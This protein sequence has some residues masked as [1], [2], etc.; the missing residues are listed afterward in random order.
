MSQKGLK[1]KKFGT[2]DAKGNLMLRYKEQDI[3]ADCV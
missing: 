2:A 3:P 1:N